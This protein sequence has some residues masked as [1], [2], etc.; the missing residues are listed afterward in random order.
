MGYIV[1]RDGDAEFRPIRRFP[2]MLA[3]LIGALIG[4]RLVGRIKGR[5]R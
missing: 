3:G 2:P 1:V 5:R 4:A